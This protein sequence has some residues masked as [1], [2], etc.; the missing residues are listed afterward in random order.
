MGKIIPFKERKPPLVRLAAKILKDDSSGCWLWRGSNDG[1][2]G[3]GRF[4]LNGRLLGAHRASY[5][6]HCGPIP[7]G[8]DIDHICR[9]PSCVNP[10]HLRTATRQENLATARKHGLALGGAASGEKQKSKTHCPQGHS[11]EDAII[12]KRGWRR[13]RQC[14]YEKER[15][16]KRR[17]YKSRAKSPRSR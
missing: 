8:M 1:D 12:T 4:Y 15:I 13:C 2:Q 7:D 10:E 14:F 16:R 17:I 6:L 9:V 3:Y 5:I 11:Y